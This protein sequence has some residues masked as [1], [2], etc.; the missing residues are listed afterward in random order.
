[1]REKQQCGNNRT[2]IVPSITDK[3][4]FKYPIA[5]IAGHGNI[6]FSAP[7]ASRLREY[8]IKGGFVGR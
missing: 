6:K 2:E 4:F 8:L 5:Y 7:E 1:M 3:D